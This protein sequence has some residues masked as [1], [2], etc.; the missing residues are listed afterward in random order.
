MAVV[1]GAFP[2][3]L[4]NVLGGRARVVYAPDTEA[5]PTSIADI[6]DMTSPYEVVGDWVDLG[7]T[8]DSSSYSK[9]IE[10]SGYEI[11]QAT[12]AVLEEITEISRQMTVS[13]A[14]IAPE[15]LL[16]LEEAGAVGTVA[17][18]TLKGAQKQVKFGSFSDTTHYRMALIAQRSR[19]SGVVVE[20]A[21]PDE[22]GRFVALCLYNVSLSADESEIEFDKGNLAAAPF[23]VTAFPEGGETGGEEYGSW[24]TEDAGTIALT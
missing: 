20:G 10:S 5:I 14:E 21:A 16:L 6:I 11:Q 7:A 15:N 18:A 2:Y 12:S 9:S 22:R 13:I 8:R 17:A 1:T 4:D 24:F 3:D 23:T 19:S